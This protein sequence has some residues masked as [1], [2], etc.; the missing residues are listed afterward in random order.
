MIWPSLSGPG[1]GFPVRTRLMREAPIKLPK[2][3]VFALLLLLFAACGAGPQAGEQYKCTRVVDGDTLV[4][5]H[6]RGRPIKVRLIG[7]DTPETVRPESPVEYFG[8]EASAFTRR[9][10]EGKKVRLEFDQQRLDKYD[11]LPAYVYLPDGTML[12]EEII[13]QGYGHVFMKFPFRFKNRFRAL[14]REARK[15]GRGLW[16][17]QGQPPATR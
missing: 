1:D 2:S 9:L 4:V 16:N 14:E 15:Q 13:R 11:R 5:R 10:A 7:V 3:L 12:N 17:D 6:E 8:R